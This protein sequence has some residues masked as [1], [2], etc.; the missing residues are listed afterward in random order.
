VG[1][2]R[3]GA[4]KRD[5][6]TAAHTPES[7]PASSPTILTAEERA[8]LVLS[9]IPR[10][11]RET[12]QE[13]R[14]LVKEAV[15]GVKEKAQPGWKTFNFDHSGAL[16]AV[17]AYQ[18]WASIGFV[19][20]AELDDSAGILEGT[21]KGM[22]HVKVKRGDT[23][24]ALYHCCGRQRDSTKSW[25]RRRALDAPGVAATDGST[26]PASRQTSRQIRPAPALDP[27]AVTLAAG[28]TISSKMRCLS[29][30]LG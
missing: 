8:A 9:L 2:P 24:P 25:G 12:V 20:G 18:N 11:M 23:A 29:L 15:P 26:G 30:W 1:L 28:V 10:H 6:E 27:H 16:A 7:S 17:S 5:G 3:T 14:D 21:G 4:A 22:R 19:R 13:L